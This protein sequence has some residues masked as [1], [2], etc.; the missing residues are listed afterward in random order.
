MAGEGDAGAG[1]DFDEVRL[2]IV[3]LQCCYCARHQGLE[4]MK[5]ETGAVYAKT[6]YEGARVAVVQQATRFAAVTD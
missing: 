5:A 1:D 3:S 2:F 4:R 6:H